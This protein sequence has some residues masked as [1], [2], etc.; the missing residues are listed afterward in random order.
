VSQSST[1]HRKRRRGLSYLEV[2]IAAAI[3][4]VGTLGAVALFPVAFMQL[5][6]GLE[7]DNANA[8]GESA[9]NAASA[10][11]LGNSRRWM[12]S[13]AS[14]VAYTQ[15]ENNAYPTRQDTGYRHWNPG[16]AALS[17]FCIDAR[18]V[19]ELNNANNQ[20]P[21]LFP[22]VPRKNI[23]GSINND[24]R[25]WRISLANPNNNALVLSQEQAR[26]WFRSADDLIFNR[27]AKDANG[28]LPALQSYMTFPDPGGSKT[29]LPG[30]RDYMAEY[31]WIATLTPKLNGQT[32]NSVNSGEY[33]MSVVVL[34]NRRPR[35]DT[36]LVNSGAS[37]NF[38]E[39]ER[40]ADV[41]T[42]YGNGIGGGDILVQTREHSNLTPNRHIEADL[43]VRENDWAMLSGMLYS[44]AANPATTPPTPV[45]P[46]FQWYRVTG[47]QAETS[48]PNAASAYEKQFTLQGA[49]WPLD[50]TRGLYVL[51]ATAPNYFTQITFVSGVVGVF[52]R[53]IRLE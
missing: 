29:N 41:T 43:Q 11:G 18:F 50:T 25:M 14:G 1:F 37:D 13:T 44:N 36:I 23:G 28:P 32:G 16:V 34:H 7:A 47:V 6:R 46:L 53:T 22:F 51:P 49:D 38:A 3:G 45:A 27:D 17:S 33:V 35:L 31:E 8:L 30:R 48:G 2:L 40:V 12:V 10:M 39:D 15:L 26:L 52:E 9:V 19:S 20:E 24:A 42:F 4:L 21:W 5:Q